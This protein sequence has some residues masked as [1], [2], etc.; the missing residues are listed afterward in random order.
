[1]FA[2][3]FYNAKKQILNYI[4]KL[5]LRDINK[6]RQS[7]I[8]NIWNLSQIKPEG[9]ATKITIEIEINKCF[10]LIRIIDLFSHKKRREF[11]S[12]PRLG[13]INEEY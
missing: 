5:D 4:Y 2:M 12:S 8:E 13:M 1:M 10:E 9:I 7:F 6:V 3:N 11:N